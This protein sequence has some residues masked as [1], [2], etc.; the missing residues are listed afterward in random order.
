MR[1]EMSG[2]QSLD[3]GESRSATRRL[4]YFATMRSLAGLGPSTKG[5]R[6]V[7]KTWTLSR[8]I[9]VHPDH[10]MQVHRMLRACCLPDSSQRRRTGAARRR[11]I[12]TVLIVFHS[13]QN[14][15]HTF[16][17]VCVE[18]LCL[19]ITLIGAEKLEVGVYDE[20]PD[21]SRSS[22]SVWIDAV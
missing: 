10:D 9:P 15:S 16:I 12:N 21:P 11:N 8:S 3:P 14:P 20:G 5:G 1:R 7:W 18:G 19:C 4:W 13:F 6:S 17:C 22:T 2:K